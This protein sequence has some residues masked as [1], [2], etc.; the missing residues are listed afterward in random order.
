MQERLFGIERAGAVRIL[1][2]IGAL[3]RGPDRIEVLDGLRPRVHEVQSA[4]GR[5]PTRQHPACVRH[6]HQI[7]RIRHTTDEREPT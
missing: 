2:T 5:H 7:F 4:A 1:C 6:E 3:I